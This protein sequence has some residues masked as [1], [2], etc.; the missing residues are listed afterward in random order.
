MAF[1]EEH[2]MGRNSE[3]IRQWTLLQRLASRRANRI[4]TLAI[5]LAVTTRTIRRD[6]DALQAAGFPIYDETVNGT[7]FWRL[8]AKTL[9]EALPRNAL[10][11]PE[12]CALYYSRALVKGIAGAHTLGDL[13]GALDKIEAA[14]PPAM[15][16]YLDRLPSVITAKPAQGQ[17]ERSQSSQITARLFE[18]ASANRVISMRYYSNESR[19][20]KEYTIHPYRLVYAQNGLYV[21]AFVPDYGE[22]R[23]FLV[24]RIRRLS[25]QE[26]VFERVAELGADPFSK[27]MGVHTGP[28]MRVQLRFSPEIAPVIRERSWHASQ[29]LRERADGSLAMTL[30]V[31][32]DYALRQWILGFGRSVR[33]VAP[34]VLADWVLEE[35]EAA[36]QQY[37]SGRSAMGVDSER[38][39]ALPFL[40]GQIAGA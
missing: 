20:E 16:R 36:G 5:D 25:V 22:L 10:T 4:P 29:Q 14:L 23:T 13:Q 1:N 15:K 9:I 8:D 40:F 2:S 26:E 38:Q 39:P 6:L 32:D 35:L 12:L 11:V 3:L 19:R 17:R 31:C 27:S 28:T 30:Q 34:Q 37:R 21:Q 7:K 18:A 24:D 33:V